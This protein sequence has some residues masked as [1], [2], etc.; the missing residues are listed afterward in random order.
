MTWR[1]FLETH[2]SNSISPY[3]TEWGTGAF[4]VA[5]RRFQED[6]LLHGAKSTIIEQQVVFRALYDLALGRSSVLYDYKNRRGEIQSLIPNITVSGLSAAS[7]CALETKLSICGRAIRTLRDFSDKAYVSAPFPS[8]VAFAQSVSTILHVL[9]AYLSHARTRVCTWVQLEY[10]FGRIGRLLE[11]LMSLLDNVKKSKSDEDLVSTLFE[12][13]QQL[14]HDSY[15]LKSVMLE[16]LSRVSTPILDKLNAWTGL[17]YNES[18]FINFH[19]PG[20]QAI[21]AEQE[22]D[23]GIAYSF[24]SSKL[25]RFISEDQGRHIFDMG[26]SLRILTQHQPENAIIKNARASNNSL[27][28]KNQ[29]PDVDLVVEKARAYEKMLAAAVRNYT[30]APTTKPTT[31]GKELFS[32][33]SLTWLNHGDEEVMSNSIS[34]LDQVPSF[35]SAIPDEIFRII[36]SALES[37]QQLE[38]QKISLT[39]PVAIL[40]N[41]SFDPLLNSQARLVKGACLR[42]L[43]RTSHL[44]QH[45]K[46]QKAFH[47]LGDGV[48]VS[49]ISAAL[50]DSASNSTERELGVM[51]AG[52][53]MG[54]RLNERH[55]WPP[56]SSELRLA[57]M[58]ILSN[59][60]FT[61][62]DLSDLLEKRQPQ[63]NRE[64]PGSMSFAVRNLP[65]DEIKRILD[66]NSLYALDFLRL[67]YQAPAP[68]DEVITP[69]SMEKYDTMFK[70]LLRLVRLLFTVSRLPRKGASSSTLGFILQAS[71]F[72]NSCACYFFDTAIQMNWNEFE[73]HLDQL[74]SAIQEEDEQQLDMMRDL[75]GID[76]LR[77]SHESC[78]DKM[79]F[80]LFLRKRHAK[81]MALLEE[82]FSLILKLDA[83]CRKSNFEDSDI[84]P[85]HSSFKSKVMLFGQVCQGLSGKKVSGIVSEMDNTVGHLLVML[86][87][88]GYYPMGT[89]DNEV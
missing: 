42:L 76:E 20:L 18:M 55:S 23:G 4:D 65:E 80:G 33:S 7:F 64:L 68:L 11:H 37:N 27:K 62:R 2:D 60:Y 57:L 47:L 5:L 28:W 89:T 85:L 45:L 46:L 31:I 69:A 1:G 36:E 66:P 21:Q 59:C 87:I 30:T 56:A 73:R 17:H 78:L 41:L 63:R 61:S 13:C 38:D 34:V 67:Q 53:G 71:T 49:Q 29:W 70:F 51:R 82:I 83:S 58:G 74:D 26:K 25:P 19:S 54:L 15:W 40:P 77:K 75:G 12:R 52:T 6:L 22:V 50:F 16:I 44:R 79:L 81:V 35:E 39:P 3:L 9:E 8:K 48:F 32:G 88:N 84:I 14:E 86:D 72:V 24:I 43:L 10:M